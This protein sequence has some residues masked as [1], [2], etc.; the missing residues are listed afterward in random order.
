MTLQ[1]AAICK[2]GWVLA[3]DRMQLDDHFTTRVSSSVKKIVVV[4][5]LGLTYSFWGNR[6]AE[7]AGSELTN[8][9][10]ANKLSLDN[11]HRLQEELVNLGNLVWQPAKIDLHTDT[12]PIDTDPTSQGLAIFLKEPF[13]F[14]VLGVGRRSFAEVHSDKAVFGDSR[15][16]ATFLLEHYYSDITSVE[17]LTFLVSHVICLGPEFNSSGV[18]GR[19]DVITHKDGKLHELQGHEIALLAQRSFDLDLRIRDWLTS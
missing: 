18:G 17:Q 19:F 4:E 3:S 14:R 1:I 13:R 12:R 5:E 2:D 9:L 10:R 6:L 16:P 15:N 11:E 8:S 7:F